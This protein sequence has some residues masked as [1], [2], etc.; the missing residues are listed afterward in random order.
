MIWLPPYAADPDPFVIE[1]EFACQFC[2]EF[3]RELSREPSREF[4]S[5]VFIQLPSA[6]S[7]TVPALR[8][9]GHDEVGPAS[10]VQGQDQGDEVGEVG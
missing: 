10:L 3:V 4:R 7:A 5:E 8:I 2:L 9:V 6:Y 1:Y